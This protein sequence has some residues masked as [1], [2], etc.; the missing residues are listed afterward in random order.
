MGAIIDK[1]KLAI[2]KVGQLGDLKDKIFTEFDP[3]RILRDAEA[4]E[5]RVAADSALPLAGMLVSVKD[6]YDEAGVAT[7]A[8]SRLLKGREPARSDCDVVRRVKDAGAVPFGRTTLSEFAYSGVGLNPH[9]GTPGNIFDP[10]GIPG[11]STSGGGLTVAHGLVDFALGTDTGGSVRI[12]SAVNGLYGYKPSRLA[13][14]GKGI[15]PLAKSFDTAGPLAK[16]LETT[17]TVFEVM[18]GQAVPKVADKKLVIGVPINA[19]TNETDARVSADFAMMCDIL[20]KAGHEL[21]EIDLG[22]V[23]ENA[24]LNKKLVAV[25]AYDIYQ[26]DLDELETC[27]DPRVLTRMKFAET[28]SSDQIIAAYG[29]RTDVVSRFGSAMADFDVMISPT[30]AVMAPKIAEVEADFDNMNATMLRN[31]SYLNLVD[32]CAISI[33]VKVAGEKVPA[34]LMIG[35]PHGHDK[36]VLD[37]AR[38][39]DPLFG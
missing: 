32:A 4:A 19:F 34:A 24:V 29:A 35:A 15:H 12:P 1:A 37:A 16:D 5:A 30:L 8:A 21:V 38:M 9:Y 7:T 20:R 22:F 6:L 13:V 23:A 11:G 10:A 31:T 36:A 33:P 3:A 39:I 14:S 26:N 27:G 2:D 17:I 28:L 18:T 25:E